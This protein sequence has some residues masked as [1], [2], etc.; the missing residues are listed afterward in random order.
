M[1][2]RIILEMDVDTDRREDAIEGL[3]K[4]YAI[5]NAFA[6]SINGVAYE[7]FKVHDPQD[8]GIKINLNK[9]VPKI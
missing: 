7:N 5:M 4:R 1:K 2:I 8:Y 6:N 9:S 3:R